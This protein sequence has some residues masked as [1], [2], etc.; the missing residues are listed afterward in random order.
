MQPVRR[1]R[2]TQV[3][4]SDIDISGITNVLQNQIASAALLRNGFFLNKKP[5]EGL[6]VEYFDYEIGFDNIRV[7][8]GQY[9]YT[10]IFTS[11]A[12]IVN[13][14]NQIALKATETRPLM[15]GAVITDVLSTYSSPGD[16]S[17]LGSIEYY[18]IVQ[19]LDNQ[20]NVLNTIVFPIIPI[21]SKN[22]FHERLILKY[23]NTSTIPN[24]GKLIFYTRLNDDATNILVYRNGSLLTYN[25]DWLLEDYPYTNNVLP[26]TG[27]PSSTG[28][29]IL[30]PSLYDIYT[31]SYTPIISGTRADPVA[32]GDLDIHNDSNTINIVDLT[33]D[34]AAKMINDNIV[35]LTN[36]SNKTVQVFLMI[37]L[38]RNTFDVTT[39]PSVLD[40]TLITSSSSGN[41]GL[42]I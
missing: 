12:L 36:F 30:F 29:K 3:T 1:L 2:A 37:I 23:K 6:N 26:P 18:S 5:I 19:E 33:G 13:D 24:V 34:C 17:Y 28:I 39:S 25:Q 11:R 9:A 42:N 20:K 31:V 32:L 21:Q 7:G 40:Y 8:Y 15:S 22:I 10:S 4:T 16:G 35:A 41:K 38:R 14:I 27:I